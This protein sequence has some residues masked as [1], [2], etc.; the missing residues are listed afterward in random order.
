MTKGKAVVIE[1]RES[2]LQDY[3]DVERATFRFRRFDG[4]MSRTVSVLRII[5]GDAVAAILHR[6]DDIRREILE[7][8]GYIVRDLR[9][10]AMFYPSP[11]MSSERMHLYYA[12]IAGESSAGGGL[13]HEDEDVRVVEIPLAAAFASLDDGAIMDAKTIIGLQWMRQRRASGLL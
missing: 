10:I 5:P 4:P 6:V 7:E 1:S 12:A 3:F 13:E 11:G 9:Q 8:T 2:V